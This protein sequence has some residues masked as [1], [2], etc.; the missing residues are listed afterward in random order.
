VNSANNELPVRSN[1][2]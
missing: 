2:N 1:K